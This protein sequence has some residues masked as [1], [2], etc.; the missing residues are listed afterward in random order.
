MR[1]REALSIA[2]DRQ[3]IIDKF[4]VGLGKPTISILAPW[5]SAYKP[6]PVPKQ[7]TAKAKRLLAE[8]GFAN[9]FSLIEYQFGTPGLIPE[10]P[11]I[12]EGLAVYWEALGI[13]VER[14][15][16]DQAAT[17]IG[18]DNKG[19]TAPTISGIWWTGNPIVTAGARTGPDGKIARGPTPPLHMDP[20]VDQASIDVGLATTQAEYVARVQK[21]N[22]LLAERWINLPLF[23]NGPIYAVKG[24]LAGD[25]WDL[26]TGDHASSVNVVA[27]MA[28]RTDI[29]R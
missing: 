4:L 23:A 7:D 27:L 20:D 12:M 3:V 26:G 17:M 19:M 15:S 2:V 22:D 11:E 29:V 1:V 18:I 6:Y 5:D 25:K 13:K 28:G 9:G 24:G 21:L 14:R 16:V 10:G 8:A